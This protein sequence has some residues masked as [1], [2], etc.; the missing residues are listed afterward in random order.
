MRANNVHETGH[1]SSALIIAHE[2]WR[3]MLVDA[4]IAYQHV[5]LITIAICM[6]PVIRPSGHYE[7]AVDGMPPPG[8]LDQGRQS[9][10]SFVSGRLLA[11]RMLEIN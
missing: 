10:I 11:A 2:L 3:G 1:F 4:V 8:R 9:S 6:E 5:R 7:K